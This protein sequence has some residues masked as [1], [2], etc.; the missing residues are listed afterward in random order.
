MFKS[1]NGKIDVSPPDTDPKGLGVAGILTSEL[2]GLPSTLDKDTFNILNRR[3]E[4]ITKQ[5]SVGLSQQES[6]ELNGI[7]N[8]LNSLG[9]K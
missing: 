8:Y 4:L 3:N 6:F 9:I 5:D 7:F 1:V 2:F